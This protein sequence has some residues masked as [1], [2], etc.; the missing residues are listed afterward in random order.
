M[1]HL[2]LDREHLEPAHAARAQRIG[3]RTEIGMLG[4]RPPQAEALHVR[5][6]GKLGGAG[7]RAVDHARERQ[8]ALELDNC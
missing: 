7:S 2:H 8:R 1:P 4:V 5:E 3:E 6:V